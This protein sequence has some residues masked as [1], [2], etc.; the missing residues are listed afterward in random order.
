MVL[1]DHREGAQNRHKGLRLSSVDE[2]QGSTNDGCLLHSTKRGKGDTGTCGSS[3][4]LYPWN[5]LHFWG[6]QWDPLGRTPKPLGLVWMEGQVVKP[7]LAELDD[8]SE[9]QPGGSLSWAL[10]L[11]QDQ[12]NRRQRRDAQRWPVLH[13]MQR[14]HEILFNH[15][16]GEGSFQIW[17]WMRIQRVAPGGEQPY[18]MDHL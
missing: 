5:P 7:R 3:C 12:G 2:T 15:Y 11:G 18:T 17:C 9:A 14:L 1:D 6:W 8:K 13:G 16:G 10:W 4:I